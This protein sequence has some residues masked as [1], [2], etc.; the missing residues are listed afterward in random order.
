M[1]QFGWNSDEVV[2]K[3][4]CIMGG[5]GVIAFIGFFSVG[6]ISKRYKNQEEL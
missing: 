5:I 4:G 1:D 2:L 3:F 6:P